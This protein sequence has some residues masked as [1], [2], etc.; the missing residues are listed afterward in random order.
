MSRYWNVVFLKS[1]LSDSDTN[2][3]SRTVTVYSSTPHLAI[4]KAVSSFPE[5]YP[6]DFD[7]WE[8]SRTSVSPAHLHGGSRPGAGSVPKHGEKTLVV[9]VPESI[10]RNHFEKVVAI[11][12]VLQ[13]LNDYRAE[14]SADDIRVQQ[15]LKKQPNPRLDG[16]R[17]LIDD[18][19]ALGY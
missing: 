9:R 1:C 11:P 12:E 19:S 5:L 10:A 13:V 2:I 3:P 6:S 14:I 16:A 18:L 7:D 4:L 15:G 8:V 17:R